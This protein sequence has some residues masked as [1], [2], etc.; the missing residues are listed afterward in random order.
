[1]IFGSLEFR[2]KHVGVLRCITVVLVILAASGCAG[3]GGAGADPEFSNPPESA[4]SQDLGTIGEIGAP[5]ERA[6]AHTELAAA[7]YEIGNLGVAIEE[8]RIALS[9]DPNYAPAY[10]ILGLV[11]M[12]LREN[13]QAQASF[14]RSLR[15][16]PTDPDTNHN[17]AWFLCQTG[18]E[19]Q[20]VR[21][22][23]AAIRN[24]LYA[25]PQKSYA[26]AGVCAARKGQDREA[27]DMLDRALKLDP[28]YLPALINLAQLR[29][30]SGE[31]ESA[32]TLI[33]QFNRLVEPTAE[34][35]WLALRIERRLG[36]KSAEA[37]FANQL[38]R[39]FPGSREHQDLMKGQYE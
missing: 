8:V 22:F 23:M 2:Q 36:D 10:N 25:Q 20:S 9:A 21:F 16:V 26:L 5:R 3:G 29:Y 6:K 12:D 4:G 38:R 14:E 27:A 34:S 19:E 35:L 32:R 13:P 30:R 18:R 17:Y 1:M 7:Y 24:P 33:G 15:I 11:H 31:N 28:N 39:R 37:N